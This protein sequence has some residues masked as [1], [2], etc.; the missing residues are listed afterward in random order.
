MS[1]I[2]PSPTQPEAAPEGPPKCLVYDY[3]QYCQD[4]CTSLDSEWNKSKWAQDRQAVEDWKE[5]HTG[6]WGT[7]TAVTYHGTDYCA[8]D[9]QY[10][11][12]KQY[13][14]L[15][16]N[17]LDD[18]RNNVWP[19]IGDEQI[20]FHDKQKWQFIWGGSDEIKHMAA[21]PTDS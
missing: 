12:I 18:I 2:W 15:K 13:S 3:V 9:D 7:P 4:T 17:V 10:R 20:M 6:A 16:K 1:S 19:L 14:Y 8:T 5:L 11:Q 21:L